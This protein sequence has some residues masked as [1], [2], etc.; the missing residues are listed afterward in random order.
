MDSNIGVRF[1]DPIAFKFPE[2]E[3]FT[4]ASKLG[5]DYSETSIKYRIEHKEF[6]LV[7]MTS[8]IRSLID[9]SNKKYQG[10]ENAGL[11]K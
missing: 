4:R 9:T 10:K 7:K 6:E 8:K 1:S 11:K 5:I 3:H 2:Q